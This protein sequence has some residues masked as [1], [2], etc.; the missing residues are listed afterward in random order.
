MSL[1]QLRRI[2]TLVAVFA[3]GFAAAVFS[4]KSGYFSHPI[5]V[6]QLV[7]GGTYVGEILD[8]RL[9]GAGTIEWPNGS[10]YEGELRGGLLHGSGLY[11]DGHG[12]RYEGDFRDGQFTGQGEILIVF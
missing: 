5:G 10:R 11:E 12:T 3:A 8:G 4:L 1:S 7:D 6:A 9:E 2:T